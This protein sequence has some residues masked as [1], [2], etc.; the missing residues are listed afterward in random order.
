MTQGKKMLKIV[1]REYR[2]NKAKTIRTQ[3][4]RRG[5][6]KNSMARKVKDD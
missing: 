3:E 5:V 2:K 4:Y 1:K 6:K